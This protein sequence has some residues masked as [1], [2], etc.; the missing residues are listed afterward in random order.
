M[1]TTEFETGLRG[2]RSLPIP[3]SVAASLPSSAKATVVVCV[4]PDPGDREWRQA[5]YEQFLRDD[6]EEDA[7]RV[8]EMR[9]KRFGRFSLTIHPEKTKL[10]K[11]DKPASRTEAVSGNGTCDLLG[12]TH[13]LA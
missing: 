7:Q 9:P 10:A 1:E 6:S 4:D 11:F 5:S 13:S 8:M 2:S 3:D 12:F